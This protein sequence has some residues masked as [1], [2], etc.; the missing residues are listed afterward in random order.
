[1]VVHEEPFELGVKRVDTERATA[2]GT[3]GLARYEGKEGGQG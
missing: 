1:M 3:W 2:A